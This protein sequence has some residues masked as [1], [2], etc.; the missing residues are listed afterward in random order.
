M[1]SLSRQFDNLPP[2]LLETSGL[3]LEVH[4]T[5]PLVVVH[6][7]GCPQLIAIDAVGVDQLVSALLDCRAILLDRL[8]K[9]AAKLS[10]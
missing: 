8:S 10:S 9:A 6:I 5:R 1:S 3:D 7:Q 2:E 4:P